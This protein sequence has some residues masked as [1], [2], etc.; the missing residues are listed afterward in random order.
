MCGDTLHYDDAFNKSV[1]N[2]HPDDLGFRWVEELIDL[3]LSITS[4]PFPPILQDGAS[5]KRVLSNNLKFIPGNRGERILPMY[6]LHV[7]E[8]GV[9]VGGAG[10]PSLL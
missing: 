4:M 3:Y 1:F 5:T 6:L 2:Y 8:G 9:V 7:I 10:N